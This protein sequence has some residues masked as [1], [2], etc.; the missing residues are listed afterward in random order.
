MIVEYKHIH[1]SIIVATGIIEDNV[2]DHTI[3]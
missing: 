1:P 2:F 3:T